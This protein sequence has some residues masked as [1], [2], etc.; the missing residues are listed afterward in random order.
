MAKGLKIEGMKKLQANLIR[1]AVEAHSAAAVAVRLEV[2]AVKDDAVTGAP[3]D[4]GEL[5][6]GIVGSVDGLEGEVR[7]TARHSDFVEHGTSRTPAQP[8]MAPAAER[9]RPRFIGRVTA[10]V[11]G[12]LEGIR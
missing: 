12:R 4:T 11:R 10:L 6:A 2:A 3:R 7:A 1:A 8:Y 9:S 5:E